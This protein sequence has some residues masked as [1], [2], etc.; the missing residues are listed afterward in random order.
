M[1]EPF[2]PPQ[3]AIG[4]ALTLSEKNNEI[5]RTAKTVIKILKN[6]SFFKNLFILHL[7]T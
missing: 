5:E 1:A 6:L 2:A 7:F 4:S 3:V